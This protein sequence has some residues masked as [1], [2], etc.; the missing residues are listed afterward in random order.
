MKNN[1]FAFVAIAIPLAAIGATFWWLPQKWHACTS[2]FDNT[3]AQII[4]FLK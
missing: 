1:L 4:C 3:P 2:L